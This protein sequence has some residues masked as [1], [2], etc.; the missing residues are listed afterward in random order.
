MRTVEGTR[1]HR[2]RNRKS[3][4]WEDHSKFFP[5]GLRRGKKFTMNVQNPAELEKWNIK[6]N[7]ISD[8]L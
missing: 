4:L 1:S 5:I 3:E 7:Q 6:Q 8:N 2:I